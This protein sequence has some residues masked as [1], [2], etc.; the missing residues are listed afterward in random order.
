MSDDA[1]VAWQAMRALVLDHHDRRAA[2]SEALGLSFIRIKALR[3]VA[4]APVLVSD[5]AAS[6]AIDRP[7]ATLVV[8][9]LENRGLVERRVDPADRRCKIV[10]ATPAGRRA[11]RTADRILGEPP[12]A[13]R[14]LPSRDQATLRRILVGLLSQE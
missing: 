5:L 3:H 9:D 2:A 14:K 4:D 1:A 11:A 10:T 6:L 7:Y 8:D 12:A 13:L